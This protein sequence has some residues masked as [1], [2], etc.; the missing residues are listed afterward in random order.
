[1]LA[2]A[3]DFYW[4]RIARD[5][6]RGCSTGVSEQLVPRWLVTT[7]MLVKS[8]RDTFWSLDIIFACE[9]YGH[10]NSKDEFVKNLKFAVHSLLSLVLL[11]MVGAPGAQQSQRTEDVMR[12]KLADI[13]KSCEEHGRILAEAKFNKWKKMGRDTDRLG[14]NAFAVVSRVMKQQCVSIQHVALLSMMKSLITTEEARRLDI[15]GEIA[16]QMEIIEKT[17]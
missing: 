5:R 8:Q 6:S 3:R 9:P 13:S 15:D 4:T 2:E 7:T 16:R 14:E 1:M 10:S 17:L 11:F 12:E